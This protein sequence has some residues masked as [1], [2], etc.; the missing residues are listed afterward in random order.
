MCVR[1]C[2]CEYIDR[3]YWRP[4]YRKPF[5]TSWR[6]CWKAMLTICC[7]SQLHRPQPRPAYGLSSTSTVSCCFDTNWRQILLHCE[8]GTGCRRSWN[9]CSRRT[10]FVVIWKHFCFI[11]ST[12]TK[13]Q[14]DSVMRPRSSIRRFNT[15]ASVT[16]TVVEKIT[17]SLCAVMLSRM[18]SHPLHFRSSTSIWRHSSSTNHFLMLFDRQTMLL[19]T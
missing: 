18:F 15:S 10:H 13:I 3:W 14:I 17:S 2:V 8:H 16:V 4:R 12:G 7:Q 19:W 1:V 6:H 9:S 11:L 5:Y